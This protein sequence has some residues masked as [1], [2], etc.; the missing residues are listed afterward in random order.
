[1][2]R[3]GDGKKRTKQNGE[4]GAK[5]RKKGIIGREGREERNEESNKGKAVERNKAKWRGRGKE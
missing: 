5:N 1:M 4:D 3:L 2:K